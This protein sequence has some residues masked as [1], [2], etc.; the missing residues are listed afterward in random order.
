MWDSNEQGS[1]P[2]SVKTLT[3][4][5]HRTSHLCTNIG[6]PAVSENINSHT[7]GMQPGFRKLCA[8]TSSTPQPLRFQQG[9]KP[10]VQNM[11]CPSCMC[12]HSLHLT[13]HPLE[14]RTREGEGQSQ[15]CVEPVSGSTAGCLWFPTH[16]PQNARDGFVPN[17]CG[18]GGIMTALVFCEN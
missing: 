4:M 3:E 10:P 13:A 11:T 18:Q 15:L 17:S 14:P 1:S 8:C 6:L 7:P 16:S 9:L 12:W 2:A 5:H